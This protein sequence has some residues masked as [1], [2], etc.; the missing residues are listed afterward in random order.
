MFLNL[1]LFRCCCF[2]LSELVAL[3]RE[4]G[5]VG[6]LCLTSL[7]HGQDL[8]GSRD[9]VKKKNDDENPK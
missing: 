2:L 3:S 5:G 6:A 8:E 7:D 4:G 9:I 1:C